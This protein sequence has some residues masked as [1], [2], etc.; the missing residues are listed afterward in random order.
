MNMQTLILLAFGLALTSC[1]Q[2]NEE[3]K[4]KEID[5]FLSYQEKLNK[6]NGTVLIA[7]HDKFLLSKGYGYR[8]FEI[9]YKQNCCK[10]FYYLRRV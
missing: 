3:T 5:A 2:K 4:I 1:V 9:A 6:F 7:Q 10:S 8:T